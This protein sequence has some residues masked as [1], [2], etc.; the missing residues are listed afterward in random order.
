[1]EYFNAKLG[2][3]MYKRIY[4]KCESFMGNTHFGFWRGSGKKEA[5]QQSK[6]VPVSVYACCVD[7]KKAFE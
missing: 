3:I 4:R 1:M 7:S 6:N 5:L 2:N